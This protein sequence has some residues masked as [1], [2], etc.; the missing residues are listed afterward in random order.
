M[1]NTTCGRCGLH[2]HMTVLGAGNWV[3]DVH[4]VGDGWYES[5]FK[6]DNCGRLNVGA[7][8]YSKRPTTAG[9]V[10]NNVIFWGQNDPIEWAP[11]YVQGQDFP[12]VPEAVGIPASEAHKC[13]SIDA[14]MSSILM[15]RA[16]IESVAKENG[17]T[18]GSLYNKIEA[19]FKSGLINEF[20]KDTANTVRVFGNDMAHGDFTTPVDAEDADGVLTFMDLILHDVYQSKAKLQRLKDSAAARLAAQGK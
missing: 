6:C 9:D 12:D 8:R 15:A 18:T 16:V 3:P 4:G 1:A 2:S 7:I 20:A 11:R 14:L 5:S 10:G 13:R 19:M 17:I